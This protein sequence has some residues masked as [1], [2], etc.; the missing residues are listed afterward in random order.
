LAS[1]SLAIG[2]VLNGVL[3]LAL[4]P[5]YGLAG[6]GAA[7]TT[8]NSAMLGVM[9]ALNRGLGMRVQPQ[10]AIIALLPIALLLGKSVAVVVLGIIAI[11]LLFPDAQLLTGEER[12]QIAT[13]WRDC[14]AKFR[15]V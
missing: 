11:C 6:A 5:A 12:R 9:F 2:L 7:T 13:V 3:N 10:T 14:R 1:V 4:I 15:P 8:S